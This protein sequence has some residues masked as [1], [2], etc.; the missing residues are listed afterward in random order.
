MV[1]LMLDRYA[2]PDPDGVLF[3]GQSLPWVVPAVA[4]AAVIARLPL[5][6]G[7]AGADEAG[8]LQVAAQWSPG[9][10]SLYGQ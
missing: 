9:G 3:R 1:Q 10:G 5:L 4:A 7:P 8:F 2:V 6:S